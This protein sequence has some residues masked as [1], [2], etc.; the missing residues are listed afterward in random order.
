MHN[1][2]RRPTAPSIKRL[3]SSIRMG[4]QSGPES[5][6]SPGMIEDYRQWKALGEG[7]TSHTWA[8]YL[9]CLS[10]EKT[11][12]FD[13]T[14]SPHLY[15]KPDTYATGWSRASTAQRDAAQRSFLKDP[16][17]QRQGPRSKAKRYVY[18]QRENDAADHQDPKVKQVSYAK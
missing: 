14:I 3:Y 11:L 6:A 5:T 17:P 15:G 9:S 8:G 12:A 2:L 7:G 10:A 1:V 13:D 18:P 4:F 16:L